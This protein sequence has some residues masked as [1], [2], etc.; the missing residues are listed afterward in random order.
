MYFTGKI[1]SDA[2][3]MPCEALGP[4]IVPAHKTTHLGHLTW[5]AA[6]SHR[7]A[8][9]YGLAPQTGALGIARA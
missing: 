2:G 6:G 4:V 9:A 3:N 8:P 1:H 5:P 7:L